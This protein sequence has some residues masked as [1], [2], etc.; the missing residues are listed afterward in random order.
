MADLPL[1][2][3]IEGKAELDYFDDGGE[4]MGVALYAPDA[5][6]W[7]I[8]ADSLDDVVLDRDFRHDDHPINVLVGRRIRVTIEFLEDQP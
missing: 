7:I 3:T 8:I 1:P 4:N 2:L 5:Q 6:Q